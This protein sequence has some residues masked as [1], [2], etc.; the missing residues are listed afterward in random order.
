MS[1]EAKQAIAEYRQQSQ[2][3]MRILSKLNE[4]ERR[5]YQAEFADMADFLEEALKTM[6]GDNEYRYEKYNGDE[7][8]DRLKNSVSS[9]W[10]KEGRV[11]QRPITDE[12]LK[13]RSEEFNDRRS[14]SAAARTH[15]YID[16][17]YAQG[18]ITDAE[19]ATIKKQNGAPSAPKEPV[20]D[21]DIP[22]EDESNIDDETNDLVAG[23]YHIINTQ[24]P[25]A[26]P[27]R[28]A[29]S[30]SSTSKSAGAGAGKPKKDKKPSRAQIEEEDDLH[31]LRALQIMDNTR[32]QMRK[33]V[34]PEEHT[35]AK[36]INGDLD[37]TQRALELLDSGD[38]EDDSGLFVNPHN[39][40]R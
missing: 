8:L 30:S 21:E 33:T 7:M 4:K 18:L 24:A 25:L 14:L 9:S 22:Y 3:L 12:E 39:K 10:H 6:Q 17:Q 27:P 1:D 35:R 32:R 23:N 37:L 15:Y 36:M 19:Y 38:E 28:R 31:E 26:V 11:K 2:K 5:K 20:R 16:Q 13:K 40:K 34:E 29:D